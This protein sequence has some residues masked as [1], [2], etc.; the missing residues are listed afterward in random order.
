MRWRVSDWHS[1][2][3]FVVNNKIASTKMFCAMP[4][5]LH[6]HLAGKDT[7]FCTMAA[8]K[9]TIGTV[10]C[11]LT[12]CVCVCVCVFVCVCVCVCVC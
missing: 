4:A 11:V 9:T 1:K 2:S 3:S 7:L 8:I 12:V 6:F 5:Q 10:V